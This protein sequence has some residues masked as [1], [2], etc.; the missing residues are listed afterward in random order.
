[1][2][3]L[4]I[5]FVSAADAGLEFII[6]TKEGEIVRRADT[7]EDGVYW[8]QR[9]GFADRHFF[10]S[11]MDF[12]TEENFETDGCAKKMFNEIMEGATA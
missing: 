6:N 10:T 9:Y 4:G 7:I 1:M 8:V 3:N 2:S 11:S 12:A 5:E